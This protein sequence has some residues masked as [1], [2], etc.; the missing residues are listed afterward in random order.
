MLADETAAPYREIAGRLG[1]SEG[2]VATVAHCIRARLRRIIRDEISQTVDNE[3]GFQDELNY[4][5]SL[6]GK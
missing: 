1:L 6:F 4:L 3:A 2:A 5:R